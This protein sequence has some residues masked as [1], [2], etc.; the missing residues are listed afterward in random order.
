MKG[1]KDQKGQR[2]VKNQKMNEKVLEQQ[3]L[4]LLR[5]RRT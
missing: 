4:V 1:G 5:Q 2:K 3:I